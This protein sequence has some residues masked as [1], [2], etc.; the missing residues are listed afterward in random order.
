M[1]AS[2]AEEVDKGNYQLAIGTNVGSQELGQTFG[3]FSDM[4]ASEE[5]RNLMEEQKKIEETCTDVET[6]YVELS[7]L[8]QSG[9]ASNVSIT[10]STRNL[11]T[12]IATNANGQ[13]KKLLLED[14]WLGRH[15]G[16]FI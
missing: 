13:N 8:P 15:S 4:I 12:T 2:S 10:H 9:R 1:L 3:R 6:E 11:H 7:F 14:I 5:N 16:G